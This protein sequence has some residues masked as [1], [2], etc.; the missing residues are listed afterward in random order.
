MAFRKALH[1]CFIPHKTKGIWS[2]DQQP[3]L[4]RRVESVMDGTNSGVVVADE[5]ASHGFSMLLMN[6]EQTTICTELLQLGP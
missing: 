2:F 6:T 1:K 5:N 4:S 3:S